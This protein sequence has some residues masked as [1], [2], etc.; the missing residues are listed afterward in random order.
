MLDKGL[1]VIQ[2]DEHQ[3]LTYLA[4]LLEVEQRVY[5]ERGHLYSTEVWG[6][7]QFVS[8][9]AGKFDTSY[10]VVKEGRLIAFLICSSP[11]PGWNHVHRVAVHPDYAGK[12]IGRKLMIQAYMDWRKMS[13][14]HTI[15]AII[16]RDHKLSLPF[17]LLLGAKVAD[18]AFM[19]EFFEARKKSDVV[20][21]DDGF[22]DSYGVKYVLVWIDKK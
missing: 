8:E 5:E 10:G 3:I 9:L 4:D 21:L 6:E 19:T 20:I 17:A 18:K 15:T 11:L 22:V 16:R 13:D 1:T 12:R 7:E 2:L 14:Y